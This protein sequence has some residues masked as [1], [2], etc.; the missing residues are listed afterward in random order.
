M[1][2]LALKLLTHVGQDSGAIKKFFF[3]HDKHSNFS[4][5]EDRIVAKSFAYVNH[6][7][8]LLHLFKFYD[9]R[10]KSVAIACLE[11]ENYIIKLFSFGDGY[12][13]KC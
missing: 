1:N 6:A 10:D 4:R 3:T 5:V 7:L 8:G 9:N 11:I 2:C 13:K 12:T